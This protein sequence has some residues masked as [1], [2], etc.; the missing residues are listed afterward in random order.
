M[1]GTEALRRPPLLTVP[2]DL[3]SIPGATYISRTA[4]T[5]WFAG[6]PPDRASYRQSRERDF[7]VRVEMVDQPQ[8]LPFASYNRLR[9][10]GTP[11]CTSPMAA[12][13]QSERSGPTASSQ[14]S[15]A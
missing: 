11:T 9:S 13:I 15:R 14:R 4:L 6:F 2:W 12:I 10:I 7:V 5:R 1:R 3:P 8:V